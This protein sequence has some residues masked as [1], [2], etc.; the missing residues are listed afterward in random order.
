MLHKKPR[1]AHTSSN[2]IRRVTRILVA[3]I[4]E[5]GISCSMSH[6]KYV[7]LFCTV[8]ERK[9]NCLIFIVSKTQ[10]GILDFY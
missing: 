2:V 9:E 6:K 5:I 8:N 4:A 10:I 3:S 7:S 1:V